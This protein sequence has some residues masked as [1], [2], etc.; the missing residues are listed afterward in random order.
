MR[1]KIEIKLRKNIIIMKKKQM[2]RNKEESQSFEMMNENK[3][4]IRVIKEDGV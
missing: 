4:F 2:M 1:R 3:E